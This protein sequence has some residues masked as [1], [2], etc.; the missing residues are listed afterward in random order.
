MFALGIIGVT[1][2]I[3]SRPW[4]PVGL[5]I[6]LIA[7]P[8]LLLYMAY[9]WAPQMAGATMR[10]LLPTFPPLVIAGVWLL[11]D[12]TRRAQPAARIAVPVVVVIVQL[13]WGASEDLTQ[14]ARL[15]DTNRGLAIVTDA[16]EQTTHHGDVVIANPQILQDLDFVRHWKLADASLVSG[17]M[18][19]PGAGLGGG[20]GG[21]MR[22]GFPGG[23]M[24]GI[25]PMPPP[26]GGGMMG[27]DGGPDAADAPS[28]MQSQ[29]RETRRTLY[30]GSTTDRRAKFTADVRAWAGSGDVYIVASSE[31]ELRDLVK[32][33]SSKDFE[34]VKRIT[35][36]AP[37][38]GG[39]GQMGNR[40]G[41]PGG[42]G[43]GRGRGGFGP[44]RGGPGDAGAGT[45]FDRPQQP[46]DLVIARWKKAAAA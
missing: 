39:G 18:G 7:L 10:F 16:L 5:M 32:S 45:P 38:R 3:C 22:G 41:G 15:H 19:G 11:V 27:P 34:I 46:R 26:D 9:Y 8:M 23:P 14:T 1:C 35:M 40:F 6:A 4:R 33:E 17:A 13:L 36:P 44:M 2:M 42:G 43:A 31:A 37:A 12:L 30:P 29:K 24:G 21:P 25:P 20:P 28:P